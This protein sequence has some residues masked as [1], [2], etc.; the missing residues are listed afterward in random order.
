LA[1]TAPNDWCWR[2]G[3]NCR[4]NLHSDFQYGLQAL[5]SHQLSDDIRLLGDSISSGYYNTKSTVI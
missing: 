3:T 4:S 2:H 1:S 5:P